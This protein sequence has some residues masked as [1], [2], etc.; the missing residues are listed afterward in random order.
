MTKK[1][2]TLSI[3]TLNI[4]IMVSFTMS[5]TSCNKDEE[6]NDP[7]SAGNDPNFTIVANNDG[8]LSGFNRKVMVFGIDIYA[9][10]GVENIKLLHAA[11][12]RLSK[13]LT[14][15]C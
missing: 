6:T 1:F 10:P 15:F 12:V 7:I 3:L 5:M 11:N 13:N 4:L 9:A 2:L 14:V 8:V